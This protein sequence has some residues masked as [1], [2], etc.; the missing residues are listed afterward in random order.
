[1]NKILI[2]FFSIVVSLGA[3]AQTSSEIDI[4]PSTTY[5][6]IRSFGASDC[7]TADYVGRYFSD[8]EKEKAA[9]WLFSSEPMPKVTP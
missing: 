7:W 2:T 9:R 3:K 8:S 6:S 4:N 1:M 5:Q